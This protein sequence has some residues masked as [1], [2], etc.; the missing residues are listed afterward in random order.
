MSVDE[1][2]DKMYYQSVC[3]PTEDF[4]ALKMKWIVKHVTKCMNLQDILLS[5]I[6]QTQKDKYCMISFLQATK[7]VRLTESRIT[8]HK[9][10]WK[11]GNGN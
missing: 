2:I 1:G 10:L 9:G 6:T 3:L 4:S 7:L 8:G 5:E 11:E